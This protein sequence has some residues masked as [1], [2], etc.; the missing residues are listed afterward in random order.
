MI[1]AYPDANQSMI[2]WILTAPIEFE[3]PPKSTV[4]RKRW[5]KMAFL[6]LQ[7]NCILKIHPGLLVHITPDCR[8]AK[9]PSTLSGG[10]PCVT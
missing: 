8:K 3:H 2:A 7:A 4:S 6:V 9:P 10:K 5:N 1:P